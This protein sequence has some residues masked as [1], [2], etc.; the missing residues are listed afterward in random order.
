YEQPFANVWDEESR[1][2]FEAIG[3]KT[4]FNPRLYSSVH[5]V[6]QP[7]SKAEITCEIQVRTLADE[8]WGEIDHKINYPHQ[9]ESLAC[10]EQIKALAR[11]A[12][13]CSRLVDSIVASHRDWEEKRGDN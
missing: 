6:I 3:I 1:A 9:H 2:Y 10:R 13:S 4:D 12:S 5:Y 7:R 8:I 11:V